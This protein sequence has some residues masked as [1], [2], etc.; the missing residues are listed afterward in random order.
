M[1]SLDRLDSIGMPFPNAFFRL[2]DSACEKAIQQGA[3][4]EIV[5]ENKRLSD[6][7]GIRGFLRY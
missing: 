3:L 5:H 7:G 1:K 2:I 4:I 6:S